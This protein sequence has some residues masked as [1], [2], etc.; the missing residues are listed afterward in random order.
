M[1]STNSAATTE[2]QSPEE[3]EMCISCLNPNA[4]GT[5]FCKHCG[6][7]L[8]SYAATAPFESILAEG[9]MWRK[10]TR[11]GRYSTVVR[12]LIMAFLVCLLLGIAAG[13]ILP[14]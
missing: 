12:T 13:L 4:P 10:A 2:H 5:H 8:T 7:P 11:R 14:R 1:I 6:T 3:L 9:D